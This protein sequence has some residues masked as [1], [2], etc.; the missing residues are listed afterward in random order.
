VRLAAKVAERR[1]DMEAA[2]EPEGDLVGF[3]DLDSKA[4]DK[5]ECEDLVDFVELQETGGLLVL[6]AEAGPEG[7]EESVLDSDML[8]VSVRDRCVD[9][10]VVAVAD[11]ECEPLDVSEPVAEADAIFVPVVLP[12][13]VLVADEDLDEEVEAVPVADAEVVLDER[14][15]VV[16]DRDTSMVFV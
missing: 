10:V 15:L 13:F 11:P 8:M 6:E 14:G 4:D 3:D 7:E 16:E 1:A 5:A 12:V 9:L 2:L